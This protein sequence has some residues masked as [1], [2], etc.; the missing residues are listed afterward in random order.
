VWIG[1]LQLFLT[2]FIGTGVGMGYIVATIS[3][4]IDNPIAS[5]NSDIMESRQGA[6]IIAGVRL[7][8]ATWLIIWARILRGGMVCLLESQ[9][10][11][12]DSTCL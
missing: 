6:W 5:D 11:A 7:L 3:A 8:A 10:A 12:R 4:L 2:L 1:S 9:I